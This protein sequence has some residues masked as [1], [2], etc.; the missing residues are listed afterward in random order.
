MEAVL[1]LPLVITLNLSEQLISTRLKAEL[2]ED[3]DRELTCALPRW[4][5]VCSVAFGMEG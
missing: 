1:Q 2:A 5:E 4:V 3:T